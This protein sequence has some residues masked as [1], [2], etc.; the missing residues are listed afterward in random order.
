MEVILKPGDWED[1]KNKVYLVSNNSSEEIVINDLKVR[2][3]RHKALDLHVVK[4][5][6]IPEK[7]KDLRKVI[8]NRKVLVVRHDVKQIEKIIQKETIIKEPTVTEA[9]IAEIVR[10][11]L[12]N[13][14]KPNDQSGEIKALIKTVQSLANR[15]I[16]TIQT[17]QKQ[18]IGIEESNIDDDTLREIH[19]KVLDRRLKNTESSAMNIEKEEINDENFI[20]NVSELFKLTSE[21]SDN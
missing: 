2:I 17:I 11:E 14:V 8:E 10:K 12:N 13:F 19:T 18:D 20:D 9:K 16:Q 7:S 4:T 6:I 1:K 21:E 5:A 15:P 3:P